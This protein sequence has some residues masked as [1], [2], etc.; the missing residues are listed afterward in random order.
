M[1]P[2]VLAAMTDAASSFVDM[3]EL[4]AAAGTGSPA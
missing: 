2:K 4:H 3:H 1:P